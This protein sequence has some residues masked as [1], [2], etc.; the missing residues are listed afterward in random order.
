LKTLSVP[1]L[2]PYRF[3][4]KMH[5]GGIIALILIMWTGYSSLDFNR[6]NIDSGPREVLTFGDWFH[7]NFGD[8]ERGKVVI[9]RKPHIA[10]YLDMKLEMFPY[11]ES[12]DQLVAEMRRSKASYLY[13]SL[14][15]AGM[16]PQFQNL[17]NPRTA[18]KE[19]RPLTY[20][21][22]PPAVL[23]KI[24]LGATQ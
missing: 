22:N 20:T 15:E 5:I 4:K 12:Y 24:D 11:V 21:T 18:P 1:S 10:Y 3:W 13:F 19:L 2:A 23:Y 7:Q 17:L 16:R 6:V 9:A 8:S 14:M